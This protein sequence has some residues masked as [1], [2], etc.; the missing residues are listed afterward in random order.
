[1]AT[2]RAALS[3][4]LGS[5]GYFYGS[6]LVQLPPRK[7]TNKSAGSSPKSSPKSKPGKLVQSAPRPLFTAVP[8]R[9]FFPRGFLWDEGFHQLLVQQWDLRASCD[10]LAHW[11][12]LMNVDGWIP[13]CA[14]EVPVHQ[15]LHQKLLCIRGSCPGFPKQTH[16]IP[17][18]AVEVLVVVMVHS[19]S[20]SFGYVLPCVTIG[21]I[22]IGSIGRS[23]C[24]L[25]CICGASHGCASPRTASRVVSTGS[26]CCNV[27][28]PVF[29][30]VGSWQRGAI[31]D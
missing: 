8:S 21:C 3:N 4:T 29:V 12:D 28:R 16:E 31:V 17:R 14:S 1:M 26:R 18:C 30:S 7:H 23:F 27:P 19:R 24:P 15:K 10:A 25:T 13:R 22:I 6:S 9:S 2:A 11:L 20:E 5:M